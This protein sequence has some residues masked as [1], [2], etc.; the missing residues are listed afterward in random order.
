MLF[1]HRIISPIIPRMTSCNSFYAHENSPDNPVFLNGFIGVLTACRMKSADTHGM[2]ARKH[3]L[4]RR[5]NFLVYF[6]RK[7]YYSFHIFQFIGQKRLC[8]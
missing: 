7:Q 8:Q 5:K 6:Y 2:K 3:P 1:W 4:I